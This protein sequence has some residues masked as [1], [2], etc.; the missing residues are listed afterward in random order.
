[1]CDDIDRLPQ[2]SLCVTIGPYMSCIFPLPCG[3]DV[4]RK[5][6]SIHYN[7][8]PPYPSYV[9]KR[10]TAQDWN[11]WKLERLK[12]YQRYV[13]RHF[14]P[15]WVPQWT[16]EDF[17]FPQG[18]DK[19]PKSKCTYNGTIT[20]M[21]SGSHTFICRVCLEAYSSR[22]YNWFLDGY[23]DHISGYPYCYTGK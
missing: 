15:G 10:P 3:H 22:E 5:C 9:W 4:C 14:Y 7:T 6:D 23:L 20:H 16:E 18:H 1:M 17:L 2:C 12:F 11:V 21:D 19:V 13:D 8:F